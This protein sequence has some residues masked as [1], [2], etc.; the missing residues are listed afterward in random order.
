MVEHG[1]DEQRVHAAPVGGLVGLDRVAV[2]AG[3]AL[4]YDRFGG[5]LDQDLPEPFTRDAALTGPD[6]V[7][8]V[9]G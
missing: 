5:L 7:G 6:E 2:L 8:V 3:V 4:V 9:G 1:Q